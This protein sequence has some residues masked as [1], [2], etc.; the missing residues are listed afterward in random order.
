MKQW[1]TLDGF[2]LNVTTDLDLF[3]FIVPCGIPAS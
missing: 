1:V 3:D 2:A